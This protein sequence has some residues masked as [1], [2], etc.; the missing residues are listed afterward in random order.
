[1]INIGEFNTLSIAR[2]TDNGFYLVDDE[3]NEVL[4]PNNYIEKVSPI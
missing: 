3:E 1:M 4:L 2:Q